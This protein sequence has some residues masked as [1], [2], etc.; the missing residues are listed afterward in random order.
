[1]RHRQ[2]L[3]N[4]SP[5]RFHPGSAT[6]LDSNPRASA[7]F[8]TVLINTCWG[9]LRIAFPVG[10]FAVGAF[11]YWR[12]PIL[13]RVLPG[14]C[15][16]YRHCWPA[17]SIIKVA[18]M[19][20]V[21]ADNSIALSGDDVDFATFWVT[22]PRGPGR[23]L[24]LCPSFTAVF[25]SFLVG[26]IHHFSGVYTPTTILPRQDWVALLSWLPSILFGFHLFVN[27][28]DYPSYRQNIQRTFCWVF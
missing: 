28:P 7:F 19:N 26:L 8:I 15:G 12:Y 20:R 16:F 13:L 17:S 25:Y 4:S 22:L 5:G 21:T 3:S 18:L 1:V 27:W 10:S 6:G 24:T 2:I 23:W 11:L 9:L 14:G